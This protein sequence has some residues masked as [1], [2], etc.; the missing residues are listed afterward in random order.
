[1]WA[2][3]L[4]KKPPLLNCTGHFLVRSRWLKTPGRT[5]PM[6]PNAWKCVAC[7]KSY[8]SNKQPTRPLTCPTCGGLL[9]PATRPAPIPQPRPAA[10]RTP[11]GRPAVARRSASTRPTGPQQALA[12]I[13][14]SSAWFPDSEPAPSFDPAGLQTEYAPRDL[15]DPAVPITHRGRAI[16]WLWI[17]VG[18]GAFAFILTLVLVFGRSGPS[19]ARASAAPAP[20]RISFPPPVDQAPAISIA[21]AADAAAT[22]AR[23][24][25]LRTINLLKLIDPARDTLTGGWQLH[26]GEFAPELSSDATQH[27]RLGIPY[28]PP[29]EYDF[30][31]DF[32][33]T[34]GDNCMAQLFTHHNPCALILFGW[35]GTVCGFQQ[36]NNQS[37]ERNSTGVRGVPTVSDQRH[38]SVVRVRKDSIEAWL[39]GKLLVRYETDG[40]DLSAKDWTITSPLG[41]GSQLSPT[42]FHTIELIEITGKGQPLR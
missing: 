31:V 42:R 34:G 8:R 10:G 12:A 24:I 14:S 3:I 9:T 22:T 36:I 4:H 33:R 21:P 16:P 41:V 11:P 37:A 32:T 15:A 6:T 1:M 17:Y 39:D 30:R 38:I 5:P 26:T 2:F 7:A 29:E 27:A 35:K 28:Q 20:V 23:P 13:T 25:A 18:G 19:S 40:S